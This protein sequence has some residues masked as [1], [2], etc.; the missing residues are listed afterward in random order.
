MRGL[1]GGTPST[2]VQVLGVVDGTPGT[3]IPGRFVVALAS[4]S[5]GL[6]ER[7]RVGNDGTQ[8]V[9]GA[10]IV[11]SS[12]RLRLQSYTVATLPSAATVA[13]GTLVYVSNGASNKRL[14][15]CDGAAWRWPDGAVVS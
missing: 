5:G 9:N 6:A 10:T 8:Y 13:A 11:D 1:L 3:N 2:A 14:A 7:F 12:A 15:V 4:S